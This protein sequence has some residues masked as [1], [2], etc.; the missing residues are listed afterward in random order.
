MEW[1]SLRRAD[2]ICSNSRY[3]ASKTESLF[4]LPATDA[5][6]YT[7]VEVPDLIPGLERDPMTVV[8]AGTLT[9][10]KGVI[11]LVKAWP[12][13]LRA[14]PDAKLQIWGKDGK[15]P[16]DGS[17]RDYLISL[18]PAHVESSVHFHGHVPLVEL[19]TVFQ[20]ATL[21]VLPS[22]A[23]GFALTPLHAMAASCPTI[24]TNRGSGPELIPDT[25]TGILIDPD[26][27][28]E[29]AKAII[30]YLQDRAL[31][32]R[33]GANGRNLVRQRFSAAVLSAANEEFYKRCVQ[34]FRSA[35]TSR[36][37]ETCSEVLENPTTR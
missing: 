8:F 35:A 11:S 1:A 15:A 20:K 33:V 14:C 30:T 17:M 2:F 18:L 22:Y 31:A 4:R 25:E 28:A 24:Y 29:I 13:V 27:P 7:P 37:R 6:I 10:K 9:E 16:A 23:E 26:K 34:R 19:M 12:E 21:T 3:I 36:N 32:E 5:V